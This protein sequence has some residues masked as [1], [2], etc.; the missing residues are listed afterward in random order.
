[1]EK[2]LNLKKVSTYYL[3]GTLFNKGAAFI[4]VPIFTRLLSTSDYGIITTY[5]SWVSIVAMILS[6]ALHM[7]VRAAFVDYE[8]KIDDFIATITTFTLIN[9]IILTSIVVLIAMVFRLKYPLLLI[10]L[11]I[12]H[13]LGA[14]LIQNYSMYLMMKYRYRFRT[15]L[16]VLPNLFAIVAS[17][18]AIVFVLKTDLYMGRIV[19]TA[20]IQGFFGILICFLIYKKCSTIFRVDYIRFALGV[21]LPLVLHGIALNILSQSDR[22]MI[23]TFRSTAETGIYSLVYNFGMIATVITTALEGV[24]VPWFMKKLKENAEK[25][26]NRRSKTYIEIMTIAMGGLIL[27]GPEIIK[28]LSDTQY[29]EGISIVPPIVLANYA[30]FAY[31]LYVNIEHYYKKTVFITLN[32]MIAVICNVITN[33]V[34]IPRL[35]YFAAA[36]TTLFSYCVALVLHARYAK[37]LNNNLYPISYFVLPSIKLMICVF[38]FYIFILNP[39]IRWIGA[40][41]FCVI[42]CLTNRE[43]IYFVYPKLKKS[44]KG[45][46]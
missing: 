32:T 10:I 2:N 28:V 17:I 46:K 16:M 15:V 24:W 8:N 23:S 4:T 31:T 39:F 1:M 40:F 37:K 22:L 33:M 29:W 30:I 25:D 12:I 42:E 26:I 11:C 19:P 9:G 21:S 38:V 36:Y 35:G 7:G 3:F 45:K 6:C 20:I 34:F 44:K 13:S 27:I 14:G 5:N 41:L 43:M 18:I